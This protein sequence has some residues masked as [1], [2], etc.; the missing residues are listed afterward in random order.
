MASI[1]M[2]MVAPLAAAAIAEP[3]KVEN[4]FSNLQVLRAFAVWLKLVTCLLKF[5]AGMFV[6]SRS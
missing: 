5:Y 6:Q 1:L 4:V 3:V 2:Q